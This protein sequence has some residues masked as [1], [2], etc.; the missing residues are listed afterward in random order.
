MSPSTHFSPHFDWIIDI[1]VIT[2]F[3]WIL[4]LSTGAST[5][6]TI[7]LGSCGAFFCK[8]LSWMSSSNLAESARLDTVAERMCRETQALTAFAFLTWITRSFIFSM[9]HPII[10]LTSHILHT[11][12]VYSVTFLVLV[13]R[14][15]S[16]GNTQVWTSYITETDFAAP[17]TSSGSA[18]PKIAPSTDNTPVIGGQQYP[19]QNQYAAQPVYQQTAPAVQV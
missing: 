10:Q 19:P 9:K 15:H 17:S 1:F 12:L 11:V 7:W 3:L 13:I 14:Q 4:W 2:A 18:E 6:D 8:C 5:A 16:R